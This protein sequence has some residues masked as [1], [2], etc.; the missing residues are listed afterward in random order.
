MT[1]IKQ[2]ENIE[3][4]QKKRFLK[5]FYICLFCHF[6]TLLVNGSVR[7]VYSTKWNPEQLSLIQ[8]T[9]KYPL[10]PGHGRCAGDISVHM[11]ARVNFPIQV[12]VSCSTQ[13]VTPN[14]APR[15][16]PQAQDVRSGVDY[17]PNNPQPGLG[18]LDS[19]TKTKTQS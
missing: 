16:G 6:K 13:H 18:Q 10:Y 9:S 17:W 2:Y 11:K 19:R 15:P 7:I 1:Q 8:Q 12:Y 4:Y 14:P 3:W 5:Q